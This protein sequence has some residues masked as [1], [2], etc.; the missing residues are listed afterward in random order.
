M[1][2]Y[3]NGTVTEFFADNCFIDVHGV[4]YRIFATAALR[5][6]LQI[7]QEAHIYTYLNVREDAM[8]LYGFASLAEYEA[9]VLLIGI[10][11]VGPKAALNILSSLSAEKLAQAIEYKQIALLTA[12]PGIGKK[13]AE[14]IIL[15]LKGKLTTSAPPEATASD[16]SLFNAATNNLEDALAA[17]VGLGYTRQEAAAA[18]KNTDEYLSTQELIKLALQKLSK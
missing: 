6:R 4:G 18:L 15:E 9:F 14:R 13:T 17:L 5:A 7:G 10:S 3:L 2:G 11:G 8:Q 12:A 16:T 1:I